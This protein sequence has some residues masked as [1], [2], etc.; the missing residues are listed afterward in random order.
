[1]KT[2][3]KSIFTVIVVSLALSIAGTAG[4]HWKEEDGHKM[5]YPQLPDPNGWDIDMTNYVLADDWKCSQDG[6]VADIHFWYSWRNDTVGEITLI[7]TTIYGDDR[8]GE[9]SM[10]GEFLCW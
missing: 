8:T 9:F 10:P 6:P 1:M 4:A 2:I 7:Q 3:K 5:H